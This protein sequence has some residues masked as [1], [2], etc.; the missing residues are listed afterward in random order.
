MVS[1]NIL[2]TPMT[3]PIMTE[4]LCQQITN[5][6]C[7]SKKPVAFISGGYDATHEDASLAG[8]TDSSGRAVYIVDVMNGNQIWK[9]S[10]SNDSN[11]KYS[12]PSDITP[13]DLY[14][15][16]LIERLYVGDVGGQIWRFDLCSSTTG[17]CI[18]NVSSTANWS[19]K[20]VFTASGQLAPPS[21]KIFYPP[22]VTF[23]AN[24]GQG[25]YDMLFFGTGDREKPNDTT[26]E[27]TL[28]AVK[29]YDTFAGTKNDTNLV[30]VTSDVLQS[31]A[32]QQ[33]KAQVLNQLKTMSGWLIRLN[34]ST[35]ESPN[36]GEKCDGP[37]VVLGGTV[38][39]TTFTPTPVN[40]QSV[41]TIGTGQGNLYA[42]QYQTGN[43][44]FD[45]NDDGTISVSD[46]SIGIGAGIPSGI[47]VTVINGVVTGY[48]GVA[49]GVFSPTL[50]STNSIIPLDWRIVF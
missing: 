25:T 40:T 2:K 16:G 9:Y 10:Y 41:C 38:Y 42:L 17:K 37:A 27:N 26:V 8:T 45:L 15:D 44:M 21:P 46:R 13:V 11:M 50:S 33:T 3:T 1:S 18:P 28:F 24:T 19:G 29:D 6:S 5:G 32:S 43:A 20:R 12:I 36:P 48:G 7:S 30:D 39:Y 35:G 34:K 22:D 23:E 49:G 31:N 14:G 4:S 47:I